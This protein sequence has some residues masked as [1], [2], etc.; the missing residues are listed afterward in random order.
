M[1]GVEKKIKENFDRKFVVD[2]KTKELENKK[3]IGKCQG[4]NRNTSQSK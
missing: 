3:L 1:H 4:M 2:L